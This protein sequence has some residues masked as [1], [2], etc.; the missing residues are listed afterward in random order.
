MAERQPHIYGANPLQYR[1]GVAVANGENPPV[2]SP[3]M[4]SSVEYPYTIEEWIRD[5]ERWQGAIKVSPDRQGPLLSLA[6]G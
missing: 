6:V 4:A 1:Q 5:V 3:E 2:W